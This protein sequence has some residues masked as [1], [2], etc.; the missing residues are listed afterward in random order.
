MAGHMVRLIQIGN[1]HDSVDGHALRR[2][3]EAHGPVRSAT[4]HRH[5]ETGR[6]IGVGMVEMESE[7][8]GDAAIAALHHREHAGRVLSVCWSVREA[9]P[10]SQHEQMF[11]ATN[12]TNEEATGRVNRKLENQK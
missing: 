6:S 8:D 5:H 9:D 2:L 3:F 1:L 7:H 12:L 11:G 4:I 10:A